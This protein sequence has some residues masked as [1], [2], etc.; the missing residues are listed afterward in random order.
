MLRAIGIAIHNLISKTGYQVRIWAGQITA[1][2]HLRHNIPNMFGWLEPRRA[3]LRSGG[4]VCLLSWQPAAA[5]DPAL[6]Y[7]G[8][9]QYYIPHHAHVC[10]HTHGEGH[11]CHSDRGGGEKE[12]TKH[13]WQVNIWGK[14]AL[15]VSHFLFST[16]SV[17]RGCI[18]LL[19][20]DSGTL[21]RANDFF[22]KF[23]T[24]KIKVLPQTSTLSYWRWRHL[25]SVLPGLTAG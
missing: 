23:L 11:C 3:S 2:W 18:S 24:K 9:K 4:C 8:D 20:D 25:R 22:H 21:W 5:R 14:S 1:S 16:L 10:R 12:K 15:L 17:S 7:T 6:G 13:Q 19:R